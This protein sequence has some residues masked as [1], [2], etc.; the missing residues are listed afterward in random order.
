MAASAPPPQRLDTADGGFDLIAEVK[1]ASP[2]EG[3]MAGGGV[4]RVVDLAARYTSAG[5]AAISVLT[6]PSRFAGAI[7][8]LVAV[9]ALGTTPVMRKD[10]LV[11]PVQVVEARAAGA[12]GVLLIARLCSP[13]LLT[14][15][16]DT[17]LGL[18]MF[19]LVEIFE[20]ED[21]DLAAAVFGRQVLVGVNARD[22][23]TLRVDPDRLARLAPKLPAHLPT[24]AESGIGTPEDAARA[25]ALGYRLALVGTSL[26]RSG[27]PEGVARAMIEAGRAALVGVL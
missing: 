1:L 3:E 10:F 17:A 8:H 24:V 4:D 11:D 27:D 22:L 5:A 23:A 9:S 2:S 14:E 20:E 21:L 18:G 19:V 6:E 13:Q 25:A 26:V 15:M 16:T 12:S 7:D